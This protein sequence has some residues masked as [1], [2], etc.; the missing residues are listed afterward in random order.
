MIHTHAK[1]YVYKTNSIYVLILKPPEGRKS[2]THV[3]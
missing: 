3:H 1:Y 2:Q